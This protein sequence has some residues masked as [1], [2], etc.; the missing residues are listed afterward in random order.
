LNEK[1]EQIG[2]VDLEEALQKAKAEE[3]DL[4]EISPTATPP[5]CK[6]IDYGKMLYA[7]KKK[8]Q[9]AK[10]VNKPSETKGIRLTFRIGPGDLERQKKLAEEFL[11]KGHSVR[12]QLVMKGRERSHLSLAFDKLNAFIESL[13]GVAAVDQKPK[14]SG[15]QLIAILRPDKTKGEGPENTKK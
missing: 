5:V 7:Q 12:I 8:D 15:H 6:I 11:T 13:S 3:L 2:V 10:K 9:H 4:V 14:T 1:G